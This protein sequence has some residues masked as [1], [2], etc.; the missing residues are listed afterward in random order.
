[1]VLMPR[2]KI[3]LEYDG[4]AYHGW[5]KQSFHPSIQSV[6]ED[7]AS[8]IAKE[9]IHVIGAGRTDAGVHAQGQ[10]AHFDTRSRMTSIMWQ[11]ALNRILPDD[12]SVLNT[13]KVSRLFHARHSALSKCYQYVILNRSIPSPLNRHHAWILYSPLSLSKMR[14]GAKIFMGT[15][16]F[17][18]FRS[19]SCNSKRT[20]ITL[21][22]LEIKKKGCFI[23]MQFEAR[24]FLMHMIRF[25]VGYLVAIGQG[26]INLKELNNIFQHQDPFKPQNAPPFGLCL[27]KV[28]YPG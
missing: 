26:K 2:F 25:L 16:D 19:S 11:K 10:V 14:A 17:I 7:R 4:L 3:T 23:Y 5:Q 9:A 22:H 24:S 18:N 13:E 28:S 8:T 6:L 1:M 12:I 20:V 15:H 21:E 27:L